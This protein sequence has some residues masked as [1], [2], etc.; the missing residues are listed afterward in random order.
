MLSLT[1]L[2]T[3][4]KKVKVLKTMGQE[5]PV[6]SYRISGLEE[7]ALKGSVFLKLPDVFSQMSI[8]ATKDNIPTEQD[9]RER[10]YLKEVELEPINASIG[11][12][13]GANA[14]RVLEPWKV[15]DSEGNGPFAVKTLLG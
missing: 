8:P 15:I 14:P 13:I 9:L 5:N 3:S 1:E 7:A 11:L 4:G 6:P 10:P 12:L 2:N